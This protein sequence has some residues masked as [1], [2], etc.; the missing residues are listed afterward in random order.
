MKTKTRRLFGLGLVLFNGIM[1]FLHI[2]EG[3]FEGVL[4]SGLGFSIGVVMMVAP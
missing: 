1:L 4:F 3:N 2:T